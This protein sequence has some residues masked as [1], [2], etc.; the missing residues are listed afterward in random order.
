MFGTIDDLIARVAL[1]W[2]STCEA[3]HR[4]L[5]NRQ[6]DNS[7][8]SWHLTVTLGFPD[9]GRTQRLGRRKQKRQHARVGVFVVVVVG[10]WGSLE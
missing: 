10:G 9:I 8:D 6:M 2:L 1:V 7:V 4:L 3:I 5:A